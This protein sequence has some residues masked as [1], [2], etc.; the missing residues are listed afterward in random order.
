MSLKPVPMFPDDPEPDA[1]KQTHAF[2]FRSP[3]NIFRVEAAFPKH[4]LPEKRSK[5]NKFKPF[6]FIYAVEVGDD[7][8]KIGVTHNPPKRFRQLAAEASTVDQLLGAAYVS[9]LC[10]NFKELE[11][12][13]F[14]KLHEFR[15][16]RE[17]F[18][19]TFKI[20]IAVLKAHTYEFK[21]IRNHAPHELAHLMGIIVKSMFDCDEYTRRTVLEY[22][23]ED[24]LKAWDDS[25]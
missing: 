19:C 4:S 5:Y 17:Y 9:P 20:V 25:K 11:R 12:D 13:S 2:T 10:S 8:V 24:A 15:K 22:G 23:G 7:M 1:N 14:R 6:G 18:V 21:E 3:L 16:T